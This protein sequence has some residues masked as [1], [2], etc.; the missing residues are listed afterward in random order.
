MQ[1]VWIHR[2]GAQLGPFGLAELPSLGITPDTMIWYEGLAVWTE[3]GKAPLTASMFVTDE[4]TGNVT[5]RISADDT[6]KCPPTYLMWSILLTICCCNPVGI[7]PIILGSTVSSK[8]RSMDYEGARRASEQTEW[9]V[10][11]TFVLGLMMLPFSW[12]IYL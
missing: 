7:I 8:F 12:I 9:A 5:A 6:R 10:I 4:A 1:K 2:D 11:I 3:A